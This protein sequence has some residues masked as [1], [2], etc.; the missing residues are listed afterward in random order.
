MQLEMTIIIL[1]EDTSGK[2]TSIALFEK[3][4]CRIILTQIF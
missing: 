1:F 2:Y 4:M 3:K